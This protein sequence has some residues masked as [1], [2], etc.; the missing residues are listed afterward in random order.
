MKYDIVN[1]LYCGY[2]IEGIVIGSTKKHRLIRAFFTGNIYTVRKHKV[3]SG[4]AKLY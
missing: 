2:R 4:Y 3:F 1:F